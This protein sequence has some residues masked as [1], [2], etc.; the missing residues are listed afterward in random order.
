VTLAPAEIEQAAAELFA[1]EAERRQIGLLSLRHPGLD[2]DDAYA[3]QAA[4]VARMRAAGRKPAGW[5]IGLTSKA[6]QS[7]LQIDTPDSGLLFEDMLFDHGAEIPRGR[8]IEPRVEAEIAFFTKAALGGSEV[9][10]AEVLAASITIV[11]PV[12]N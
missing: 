4:L 11:W 9:T 8:F 10:R 1:A 3:I 12:M 6:M 2:L 5:K 7:A